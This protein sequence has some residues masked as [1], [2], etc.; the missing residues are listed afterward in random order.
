MRLVSIQY[1]INEI[2]IPK[3][4]RHKVFSGE[5]ILLYNTS[6]PYLEGSLKSFYERVFITHV[7]LWEGFHHTCAHLKLFSVGSYDPFHTSL[8]GL[9]GALKPF[10]E[11]VFVIH[12]M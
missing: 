3:C 9:E 10:Y 4:D 6:L 11:R 1:F 7:I 2:V 12:L 8:P 5:A